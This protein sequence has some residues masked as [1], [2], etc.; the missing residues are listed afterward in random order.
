MGLWTH[1]DPPRWGPS[2][3]QAMPLRRYVNEV[4][5]GERATSVDP[6]RR[7]V[8]LISNLHGTARSYL[9]TL[10]LDPLTLNR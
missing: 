9:D 8:L 3:E 5:L 10:M 1:T 6:P 7:I 2:V 4:N